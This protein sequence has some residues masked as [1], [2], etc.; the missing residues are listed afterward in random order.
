MLLSLEVPGS[1]P[2]VLLTSELHWV[3][4]TDYGMTE[5]VVL[6]IAFFL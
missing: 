5:V 1:I 6:I 3:D 4:I 2:D